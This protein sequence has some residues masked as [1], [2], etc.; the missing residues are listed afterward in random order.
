MKIDIRSIADKGNHKKERLVLKVKANTDIGDYLVVQTG[1]KDG[2]V[3]INT[4]EAYWFPYKAILSG[5]V[6]VL[7]TKNGR[8]NVKE[9]EGGRKVHF[10]YWGLNSAIWDSKDKAPVVLYAP[11]WVNKSPEEL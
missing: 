5:D 10:F 7:Y 2:E 9:L 3:T 4:Y 11:E 6:V 1:F 8:E